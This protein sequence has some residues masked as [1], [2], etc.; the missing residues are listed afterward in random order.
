[1]L[2][3]EIRKE[4][5]PTGQRGRTCDEGCGEILDLG[6]SQ[7][8]GWTWECKRKTG[9][10]GEVP[11]EAKFISCCHLHHAQNLQL[12][13]LRINELAGSSERVLQCCL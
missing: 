6:D 13:L 8:S 7:G 10:C 4:D 12:T 5:G 3:C 2:T 1:M 9:T 11:I